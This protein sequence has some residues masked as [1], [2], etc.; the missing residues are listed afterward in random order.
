M[1]CTP[2]SIHTARSTSSE[3]TLLLVCRLTAK[4]HLYRTDELLHSRLS[5]PCL[6]FTQNVNPALQIYGTLNA[7]HE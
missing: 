7:R 4:V 1:H 6:R 2:L 3:R 5:L